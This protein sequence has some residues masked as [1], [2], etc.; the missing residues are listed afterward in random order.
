M[1]HD[2][3]LEAGFDDLAG[4]SVMKGAGFKAVFLAATMSPPGIEP[5]LE[6]R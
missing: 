3:A 4:A 1:T 6:L 5:P 2:S